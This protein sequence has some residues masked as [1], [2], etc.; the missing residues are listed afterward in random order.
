MADEKT[1]MIAVASA[2]MAYIRNEEDAAV[3]STLQAQS[4]A[5]KKADV[6]APVKLWGISGR[7]DMMH[8]RS[9]MQ[10]KAFHR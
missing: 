8:M 4:P 2:V 3:V 7:Q 9:M 6:P 5:A 10:L 1:K